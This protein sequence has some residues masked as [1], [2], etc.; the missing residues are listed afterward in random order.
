MYVDITE[1]SQYEELWVTWLKEQKV[2]LWS[3]SP[4]HCSKSFCIL[5]TTCMYMCAACVVSEDTSNQASA[6]PDIEP[7][8]QKKG[9]KR[10]SKSSSDKSYK[11]SHKK[12]MSRYMDG[13]IR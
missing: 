11:K 9:K 13:K 12:K 3:S 1:T 2:V 10:K 5:C 8:K 4:L 6:A 7:S